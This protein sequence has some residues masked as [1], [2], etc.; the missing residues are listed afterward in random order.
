MSNNIEKMYKTIKPLVE[1]MKAKYPSELNMDGLEPALTNDI[2]EIVL[3]RISTILSDIAGKIE[4]EKKDTQIAYQDRGTSV[5]HK[6][7]FNEALDKALEIIKSFK[8]IK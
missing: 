5:L 1:K 8:D 6:E 2:A 3:S 7:S 4:G